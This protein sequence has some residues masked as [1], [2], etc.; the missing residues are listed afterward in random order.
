MDALEPFAIWQGVY[1]SQRE[2]L[3][4]DELVSSK[5]RKI[6]DHI[7]ALLDMLEAGS[8]SCGTFLKSSAIYLDTFRSL[9]VVL[10]MCMSVFTCAACIRL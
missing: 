7:A 4:A 9:D 5:T 8:P 1:S 10:S 3:I 6:M 2:H